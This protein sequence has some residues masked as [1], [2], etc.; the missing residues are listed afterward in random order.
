MAW[1]VGSSS[2]GRW[3]VRARRRISYTAFHLNGHETSPCGTPLAAGKRMSV[4]PRAW[5]RWRPASPVWA[6]ACCEMGSRTV[7]VPS[8]SSCMRKE[9]HSGG[10]PVGSRPFVELACVCCRMRVECSRRRRD[11]RYEFLWRAQGRPPVEER[12]CLC[13]VW[14]GSH[15]ATGQACRGSPRQRVCGV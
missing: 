4:A 13:H 3:S 9:A 12:R 10:L 14:H 8:R 6:Y 1:A 11:K 7:V 5:R 2:V 15:V